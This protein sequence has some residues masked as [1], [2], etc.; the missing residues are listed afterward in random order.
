MRNVF[1][2][3]RHITWTSGRGL[4]PGNGEFL[5]PV[6]LHRADRRVSFGAQKTRDFV[7]PF[8]IAAAEL[9][10]DS[11]QILPIRSSLPIQNVKIHTYNNSIRP[12]STG[13]NNTS[14][15]I[16]SIRATIV[17]LFLS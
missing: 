11:R 2:R 6:K 7:F 5:G 4:G 16:Y 3:G 10:G 13:R 14:V 17:Y 8:P 15:P 1:D 9:I 12:N